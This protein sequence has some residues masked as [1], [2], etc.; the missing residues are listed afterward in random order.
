MINKAGIAPHN[1]GRYLT[2]YTKQL[3]T[4]ATHCLVRHMRCDCPT[5]LEIASVGTAVR[6]RSPHCVNAEQIITAARLSSL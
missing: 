2:R 6:T 3:A 1:H 4:N 5:V